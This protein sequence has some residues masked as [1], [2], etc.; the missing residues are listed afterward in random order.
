M[1]AVLIMILILALL[2][3]LSYLILIGIFTL[4]WYRKPM[5]ETWPGVPCRKISVVVAARNEESN[6]ERLLNDLI[7]QDYPGDLFEIIIV[8]DHSTDHT[9]RI[10]K[11]FILDHPSSGIVFI[12]NNDEENRG[13]KAS[14]ELGISHAR[15][16]IVMTTDADCR[17]GKGWIRALAGRFHEEQVQMV[18]G[19]V[20]IRKQEN[21]TGLFQALEFDG[22]VASGGGAALAGY[23]F[24]CNGANLAYRKEAFHTTGG[25]SDNRRFNSGDDVFLLH[26]IKKY[27]G[28]KAIVFCKDEESIVDTAPVSGMGAFLRQRIRWASKSTG[29]RDSLSIATAITVF[30]YSLTVLL[31]FLAGF[32]NPDF[33]C[34]SGGLLLLKIIADLPLLAGITK[35]NGKP[36][37]IGWYPVFQI[38]YPLYIIMAGILSFSNNKKW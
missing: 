32:I 3:V 29:Y 20:T 14:I 6:M 10:T 27:Y 25:F 1:T 16:E 21:F 31:S 15:G 34:I 33:F 30:T 8:D 22:L 36:F 4:G 17:M 13:K 35:F 12:L 23:P 18:F 2:I 26:K 38:I 28:A 24:L 9:A 7:R 37:P 19:P 11:E 5:T